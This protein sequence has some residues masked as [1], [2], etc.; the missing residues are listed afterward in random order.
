MGSL[1][2]DRILSHDRMRPQGYGSGGL[3]GTWVRGWWK[4]DKADEGVRMGAGRWQ[5]KMGRAGDT[6]GARAWLWGPL[7]SGMGRGAGDQG[8][9]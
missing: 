4:W 3:K 7:P 5:G 9:A 6:D 8:D 1:S 2:R